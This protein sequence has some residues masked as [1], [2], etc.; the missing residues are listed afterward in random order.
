MLVSGYITKKSSLHDEMLKKHN[1]VA[2]NMIIFFIF[3]INFKI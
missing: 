1:I 3:L 2:I